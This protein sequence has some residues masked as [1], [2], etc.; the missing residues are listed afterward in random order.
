MRFT[1]DEQELEALIARAVD[2]GIE[3]YELRKRPQEIPKRMSKAQL[4]KYWNRSIATIDRYMKLGMPYR[5][6]GNGYPEFILED[7]EEW[8]NQHSQGNI[9]KT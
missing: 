1:I 2:R 4:A 7:V 5:K 3:I 6:I 8:Y 9:F